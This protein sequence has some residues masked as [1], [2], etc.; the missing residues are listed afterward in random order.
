MCTPLLSV[1]G[2]LQDC[3]K[4]KKLTDKCYPIS[5]PGLFEKYQCNPQF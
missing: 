5:F 4:E 3:D 1:I 2:C